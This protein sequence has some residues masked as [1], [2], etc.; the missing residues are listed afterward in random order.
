MYSGLKIERALELG[1]LTAD[2]V[3]QMQHLASVFKVYVDEYIVINESHNDTELFSVYEKHFITD[4]QLSSLKNHYEIHHKRFSSAND[5]LTTFLLYT[6][7]RSALFDRND[8]NPR[9]LGYAKMLISL[10]EDIL[11]VDH[12]ATTMRNLRLP[13]KLLH[14]EL[15]HSI[16]NEIN[17]DYEITTIE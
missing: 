1:Y 15:Q 17:M 6:S 2:I 8:I 13:N 4:E 11:V 9:R 7:V 14:V 12:I 3:F 5:E 16:P 10:D